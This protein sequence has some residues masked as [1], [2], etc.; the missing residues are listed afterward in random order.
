MKKL[1]LCFLLS[2]LA[3]TA[4][5]AA[6]DP[7]VQPIVSGSVDVVV[8]KVDSVEKGK[9]VFSTAEVFKGKSHGRLVLALGPKME[10][11]KPVIS[12]C[13]VGRAQTP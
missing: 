9:I 11:M 12:V 3:V 7:G 2:L 6:P 1:I 10:K 8:A 13:F 5:V 4:A